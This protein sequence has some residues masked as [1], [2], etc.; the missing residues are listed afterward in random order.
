MPAE[1]ICLHCEYWNKYNNMF[2][3]GGRCVADPSALV[4]TSELHRCDSWKLDRREE[5]IWNRQKIKLS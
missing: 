2:G 3:L 4:S 1:R 5:N